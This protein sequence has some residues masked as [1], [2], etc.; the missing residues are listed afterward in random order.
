MYWNYWY[1]LKFKKYGAD[2]NLM[3]YNLYLLRKSNPFQDYLRLDKINN[4]LPTFNNLDSNELRYIDFGMQGS[5]FYSDGQPSANPIYLKPN[6]T[7]LRIAQYIP[8]KY[9]RRLK[10][11]ISPGNKM[12]RLAKAKYGS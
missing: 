6:I 9:R 11:I 10:K 8:G 12:Y 2:V 3:R 1:R 4:G 5:F 7:L